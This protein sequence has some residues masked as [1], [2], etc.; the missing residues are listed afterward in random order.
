MAPK[1]QDRVKSTNGSANLVTNVSQ[2]PF[3]V[4]ARMIVRIIPTKLGVVSKPWNYIVIER[5]I[6]YYQSDITLNSW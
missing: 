3:T 4:M 2:N 5:H 6:N 1:S